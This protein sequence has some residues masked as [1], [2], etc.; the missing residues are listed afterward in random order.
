M[1]WWEFEGGS[2][3]ISNQ[4]FGPTVRFKGG[5]GGSSGKVEYPSYMTIV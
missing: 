3:L 1:N 2:E 5:G 4:F